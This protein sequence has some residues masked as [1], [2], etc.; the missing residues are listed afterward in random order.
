V[1]ERQ[2]SYVEA[3]AEGLDLGMARDPKVFL[4]GLGVTD[5][6]A[7]FG[8]V[9]GVLGKYGPERVREMPIAEHGM[10]GIA[11]GAAIRGLRPVMVHMRQEFALLAIDQIINQA[12]KW[13]YMF[14]GRGTVPLVLRIIVGRGWGQGPQHSQSL[15]AWFAHMPGLRVVLP[16]SPRDAKGMLLGALEQYSP[17]V[18]IEHRWLYG[19]KGPVPEGH[20][21][22]P[23]DRARVARQGDDVTIVAVGYM[24]LEA[25][26][27]AETLAA[28]GVQATVIDL[29]SVNPLDMAPVLESLRRTGRLVVADHGWLPAGCAADVVARAVETAFGD[30]KAA[31]ERVGLP[32]APTPTTR[33][34]ANY[35]YPLSG[36]IVAAVERSFGRK[37]AD[38]K[39]GVRPTDALDQPDPGFRGLF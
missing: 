22:V 34:L 11:V 25:L 4:L 27:A 28:Q 18:S 32:F 35:Y 2:I 23:L 37:P 24:V 20:Y 33:G 6:A 26:R 19:I 5:A 15:H 38:P 39:A 8:S 13:H 12:A 29:R 16:V 3:L 21:V 7:I 10:T 1:S 17:V 14:D 30:F 31:P 9:K 36:D